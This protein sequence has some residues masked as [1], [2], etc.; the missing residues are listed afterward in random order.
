MEDGDDRS[1]QR[2]WARGEAR[3]AY[4]AERGITDDP[5]AKIEATPD[6][7]LEF[8]EG[9]RFPW[10]V[11]VAIVLAFLTAD[12]S[13]IDGQTTTFLIGMDGLFAFGG[14]GAYSVWWRIRIAIKG[15]IP[16]IDRETKDLDW[17]GFVSR[18]VDPFLFLA[19]GLARHAHPDCSGA[20]QTRLIAPATCLSVC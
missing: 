9:A 11:T 15:Q 14:M 2:D 3:R 7:V 12:A 13:G 20:C 1:Q 18:P 16:P 4:L 8:F 19:R 6:S 10:S 5:S 17:P